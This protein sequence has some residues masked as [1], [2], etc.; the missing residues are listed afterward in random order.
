M[1]KSRPDHDFFLIRVLVGVMLVLALGLGGCEFFGGGEA[2]PPQKISKPVTP[3]TGA[4]PAKPGQPPAKAVTGKPGPGKPVSKAALD[5]QPAEKESV[6]LQKIKQ[7]IEDRAKK[8]PFKPEGLLDPFQPMA[9]VVAAKAAETKKPSEELTLTPLQRLELSQVKLVA[10]VVAGESTRALVED[11]TGL[12]Y[13]IKKGTPIG[14]RQGK[15]L[16]IHP[17]RVEVEE[18]VRDF[19]G[20]QKTIVSQLKL[21]AI[22]KETISREGFTIVPSTGEKK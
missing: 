3:A 1:T 17:D 18:I 11:A 22:Q 16:A 12:G 7:Q 21:Q 20:D 14:R 6:T 19:K 9:A 8:Y 2:P 5:D 4:A 10:I 13:I 15:V